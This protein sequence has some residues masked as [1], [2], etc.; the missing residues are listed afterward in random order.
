MDGSLILKVLNLLLLLLYLLFEVSVPVLGS[1]DVLING[2]LLSHQV[3]DGLGSFVRSLSERLDLSCE[4]IHGS[5]SKL[6]VGISILLEKLGSVSFLLELVLRLKS[7]L[8]LLFEFVYFGLKRVEF[9]L[10][11]LQTFLGFGFLLLGEL[12][13]GG[14]LVLLLD[15]FLGVGLLGFKLL[16]NPLDLLLLV[17]QGGLLLLV[18]LLLLF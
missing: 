18:N 13:T 6:S 16:L 12:E 8:V 7:S 15:Q 14:H 4:G 2:L 9:L 10:G 11:A 1:F 3:L 5:K 17:L